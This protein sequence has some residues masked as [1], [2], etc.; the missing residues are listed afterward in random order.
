MALVLIRSEESHAAFVALVNLHVNVTLFMIL[1]VTFS[2]ELLPAIFAIV[3][4][5]SSVNF[6]VLVKAALILEPLATDLERALIC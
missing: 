2:N 4:F 1:P 6:H 3:I 5:L